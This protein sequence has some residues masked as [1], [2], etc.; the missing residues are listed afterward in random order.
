MVTIR[1]VPQL[2]NFLPLMQF[3]LN[4]GGRKSRLARVGDI[5]DLRRIAKRRTPAGPFNYVDGG[6]QDEYTYRGNREAFRNLEFDP[7]ILAGSADVDLSTTIAGVESRL[8]VGIAP[9]GFT[10]MMHTEGEVAGV[11]TADRFGV[12]FTLSTMGTRS[13]EDVASCA[14]NA[15]KWFQLYLW[16]DRD[17]SQDLLERAWKN[18][19]ETLL[20]T[21]DTT[22]AG[23]R[24]RDV[25]HGLT[26]PPKLSAGTVLDAS[27]RPEWWFNFLTTDPLTYASLSNEVSD[28]AS[29]T[30]SMFDPTLSFEDL[31]WIRSVWPGKLFV[32]GVLTEVDASKSLDAGADGLVVSNHGGR[33]LDRAPITLEALPVVREAV[34]EDVP[35]ILDSG[36]M[37]GQ[38]IIGALALGADFTLIGRAYLYGLM[39]AGEAGVRK[40]FEI[41][42]NEMTVTMQLM[43]A[44]SIADLN[45]DMVR[46][47]SRNLKS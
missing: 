4:L 24:L 28:L 34:G 12:P 22:V 45:P 38:D 18:G 23:R 27:Y 44:G 14:P 47:Y 41:L 43:G 19:F 25:R 6:A 15:T 17:A 42:E 11:R 20:V 36:I 16:R 46:T 2:K 7:A 35:I 33:Q 32:K 30:S 31:K 1:R 39:A 9:T 40:V 29:L 8:P 21:V 10:R 37:R 26:I 3:D 13:I 5:D